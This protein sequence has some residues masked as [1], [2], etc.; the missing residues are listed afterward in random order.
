M[1]VLL[2]SRNILLWSLSGVIALVV[3]NRKYQTISLL[4]VFLYIVAVLFAYA[5]NN[6]LVAYIVGISDGLYTPLLL[7]YFDPIV[8]EFGSSYR[9][10]ST[11]IYGKET[12]AN[13]PYGQLSSFFINLLPSFLKPADFVTFT[14]YISLNY[15]PQGEGIGSSPM[16]EAHLSNMASIIGLI[17]VLMVVYWPAYYSRKY[18]EIRLFSYLLVIAVGFNI[19]R[20]GSAE[21]VKMFLSNIVV[22]IVLA[23]VLGIKVFH[24]RL[25][26]K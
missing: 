9:T 25:R 6:G 11:I 10:F 7:E 20:I 23:K 5:R 2:G 4:V 19:W 3:S 13:A 21:I 26:V 22:L 18:H 12:L 24:L 16:T 1:L 14:N 15:A 17:V 8:H